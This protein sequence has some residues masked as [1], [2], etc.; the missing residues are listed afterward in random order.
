ML[1]EPLDS[2]KELE[3]LCVEP[4][5]VAPDAGARGTANPVMQNKG[6]APLYLEEGQ[7]LAE[8]SVQIAQCHD[9]SPKEV[10]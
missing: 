9:T 5:L 6:F 4:A 10:R 8:A 2:T 1:L 3:G 7:I